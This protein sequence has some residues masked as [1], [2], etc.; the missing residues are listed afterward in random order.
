MA[1]VGSSGWSHG[2]RA[3]S[4]LVS[5]KN[6]AVARRTTVGARM[7]V[8]MSSSSTATTEKQVA[9]DGDVVH[10]E[11]KGTAVGDKSNGSDA[12]E[13]NSTDY[14][15]IGDPVKRR[16]SGF[17]KTLKGMTVGEEKKV[18]F[19][20]E[21]A[22]GEYR[23]D[24]LLKVPAGN[25]PQGVKV[26][27]QLRV[28]AGMPVKVVEMD[29]SGAVI[30]ANSPY[31]GKE[32]DMEVKLLGIHD[33]KLPP[34][35]SGMERVIFAAG[36]FWGVELAFQREPGVT[37]TFVGYA[38]G[39]TKNPLYEEVCE[40]ETG[41]TEA[42]AVYYDPSK[43]S[44]E[45]LLMLYWERLGKSALTLNRAGNDVGTQYR[46]G[47]YCENEEQKKMALE[48]M[49]KVEQALDQPVVTEVEEL[50]DFYVAEEYHQQYLEKGGQSAKKGSKE[51]IRCYG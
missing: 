23:N 18:R 25:L 30:D 45:R 21:D 16:L 38:Q 29:S 40:G 7:L 47:I 39:E 2:V 43:V 27:T 13:M 17:Y 33:F 42:V 10:F 48:S 24:L 26:G 15:R 28:G 32:L 36:C 34:V 46:S 31:A 8:R 6:P 9:S 3:G 50:K 11:Y 4:R 35:G 51:T 5:W 1:F 44:L 49:K 20:S 22:F 41:H 12:P 14:I 37:K 19:S